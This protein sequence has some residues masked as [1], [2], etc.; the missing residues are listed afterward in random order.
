MRKTLLASAALIV[1]GG[2]AYAEV[3][4]TGSGNFGVKFDGAKSGSEALTFHHEF[5]VKFT[6]SGTTDGGL[7]FGGSVGIDDRENLEATTTAKTA[8]VG[9]KHKILESSANTTSCY[10]STES[11]GSALYEKEGTG[12]DAKYKRVEELYASFQQVKSNTG[13]EKEN[14]EDM[15]FV[16]PETNMPFPP[17][18]TDEPQTEFDERTKSALELREFSSCKGISYEIAAETTATTSGTIANNASVHIGFDVHTLTI[19]DGLDAGDVAAGGVADVGFDGIG[20]D[21][22]AKKLRGGTN[23]DVVYTGSFGVANVR[24]SSGGDD[25]WG[26]GFN[27]NVAPVTIGVGFDSK[28]VASIGLGLAQGPVSGKLLYST[29]SEDDKKAYGAEIGYTISEGTSV[30][31]VYSQLKDP[32]G[33]ADEDAVG[34]GFS[35]GLGGGATLAAGIGQVNDETKADLGITMAF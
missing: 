14:L 27:F 8:L 17:K 32:M 16:N 4:V 34:F 22:V 29:A 33:G 5:D 23:V 7:T 18:G 19:G 21:D 6:A 1:M 3:S 20:V 10:V 28:K 30:T 12:R 11:T 35:H 2:G 25:H 26:V 13:V 24:V 31:I 15:I 9:T